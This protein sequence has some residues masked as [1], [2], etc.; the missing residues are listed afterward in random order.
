MYRYTSCILF[1][2]ALFLVVDSKNIAIIGGGIGGS[3]AAHFTRTFNSIFYRSFLIRSGSLFPEGTRITLFEKDS[4][5]G[6]RLMSVEF[7]G[8][9]QEIGADVCH[10]GNY[11][12]V[13]F[14]QKV[15]P[16][17][18]FNDAILIEN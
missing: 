3:A 17:F 9:R 6:G 16:N 2:I 13:E 8:Y 15:R 4:R 11:Y 10:V 14:A 7:D 12:C 5:I 1:C 18:C